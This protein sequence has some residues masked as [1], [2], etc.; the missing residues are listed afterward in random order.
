MDSI[1]SFA[2]WVTTI[3]SFETYKELWNPELDNLCLPP[4]VVA[5]Y[6]ERLLREA[7]IHC[8]GITPSRLSHMIWFFNGD[9]SG[10]WQDV[11]SPEV[12]KEEQ[13]K[14]V[15]SMGLFYKDFLN[16]YP[17][18]NR[19]DETAAETA[20]YMMWDMNG[21]EGAVMF[22]GEEHLIEPI[23]EVLGIALRCRSFGCQHSALHGLGHLAGCHMERVHREIDWA[24]AEP[25]HLHK[26]LVDYAR[27]ARKGMVL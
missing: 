6:L 1:T 10:Y 24:I 12:P 15:K 13:I 2:D 20:V 7:A 19:P 18:G 3:S 16:H 25:G 11:R 23:F 26:S 9:I 8:S 14:T 21:I 4:R 27:Y 22:P 5:D 17:L